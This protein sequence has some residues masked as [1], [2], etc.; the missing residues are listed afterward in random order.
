MLYVLSA[1]VFLFVCLTQSVVDVIWFYLLVRRDGA[2][3]DHTNHKIGTSWHCPVISPLFS[4]C[5]IRIFFYVLLDIV[6]CF[7]WWQRLMKYWLLSQWSFCSLWFTF[8]SVILRFPHW[9]GPYVWHV[10]ATDPP[11]PAGSDPQS[12]M[13]WALLVSRYN[14]IFLSLSIL[15]TPGLSEIIAIFGHKLWEKCKIF[16]ICQLSKSYPILLEI[17]TQ[18][19]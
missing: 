19:W 8:T 7:L 5:F 6:I 10:A 11:A 18:Y 1:D 14:Y 2:F 3:C 9:T 17:K 16:I 15:H 13:W 12:V 4:S